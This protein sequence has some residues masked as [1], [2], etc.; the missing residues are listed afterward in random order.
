MICTNRYWMVTTTAFWAIKSWGSTEK[1]EMSRILQEYSGDSNKMQREVSICQQNGEDFI[2]KNG[3]E[4]HRRHCL[5]KSQSQYK[6][7]LPFVSLLLRPRHGQTQTE[8]ISVLEQT[9]MTLLHKLYEGCIGNSCKEIYDDKIF[10]R[11]FYSY[12]FPGPQIW[13]RSTHPACRAHQCSS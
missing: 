11:F 10:S 4:R 9:F 5:Q 12:I 1:E 6:P 2:F 8:Q 7:T 3:W 13:C